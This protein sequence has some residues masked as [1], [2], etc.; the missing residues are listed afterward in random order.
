M[1]GNGSQRN[2][3]WIYRLQFLQVAQEKVPAMGRYLRRFGLACDSA[4]RRAVISRWQKHFNLPDHWAAQSAWATLGIWDR[5]ADLAHQ[6]RW[7]VSA[8]AHNLAEI[9]I[10]RFSFPAIDR[11]FQRDLDFGWFKQSVLGA[12]EA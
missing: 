7:F 10:L 1:V 4:N 5:S 2:S 8:P 3:V 9:G 6:L 11:E 12:V